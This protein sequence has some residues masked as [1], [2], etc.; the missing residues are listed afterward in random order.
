MSLSGLQ[1]ALGRMVRA[2]PGPVMLDD[3]D[4]S[5]TERERLSQLR[6][7]PGFRFTAS[8]Q[9]SWC[10]GRAAKCAPLALSMLSVDDRRRAL[11]AWADCGGGTNSFFFAEADAFLAFL[12]SRLPDPSH[13]LT[14]CQFER[15][16]LRA[17]EGGALCASRHL[18]TLE[19]CSCLLRRGSYAALVHFFAEPHRLLDAVQ[20]RAALPPVSLQAGSVLVAPGVAGLARLADVAEISLWQSLAVPVAVSALRDEGHAA[21]AI[22]SFVASGAAEVAENSH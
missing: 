20:D 4:L 10:E 17:A 16:I 5:A 8:I 6:D 2:G 12:A 3:L 1:I 7:S 14:I 11:A 22:A 9:R 13:A 21:D 19:D 18:G 15:A